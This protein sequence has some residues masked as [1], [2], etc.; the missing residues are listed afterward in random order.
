[1]A[2]PLR[3]GEE[4]AHGATSYGPTGCTPVSVRL[5]A[6]RGNM[7][8]KNMAVH[9]CTPV[10]V[11]VHRCTPVLVVFARHQ[12]SCEKVMG[13]HWPPPPTSQTR[14]PGAPATAAQ[15]G[16]RQHFGIDLPQGSVGDRYVVFDAVRAAKA[17]AVRVRACP[18]IKGQRASASSRRAHK[19]AYGVRK[20]VGWRLVPQSSIVHALTQVCAHLL[21]PLRHHRNTAWKRGLRMRRTGERPGPDA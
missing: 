16:A 21:E 17:F 9:R 3:H 7:H 12:V 6:I 5:G 13:R 8:P 19:T 10:F 15:R 14:T 1:M 18:G 11:N 20:V 4:A 2:R